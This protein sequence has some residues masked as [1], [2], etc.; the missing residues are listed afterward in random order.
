MPIVLAAPAA[1]PAPGFGGGA[2]RFM[3]WT[4]FD[5]STFVLCGEDA[6]PAMQRGVK[7]LHMPRMDGVEALR[8]IRAGEAG[9]RAIPVLALTADAMSGEGERLVALGFNQVHPKPIQPADLLRAVAELT[10]QRTLLAAVS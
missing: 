10:A 5:G 6:A 1:A 9:P 7:G 3:S 2:A 8:R 4:G